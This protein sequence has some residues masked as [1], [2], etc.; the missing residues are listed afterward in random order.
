MVAHHRV[1][2]DIDRE[3]V[4]QLED[5]RPDPVPPVREVPT[6]L[7]IETAQELPPHAA[8]DDVVVRRGIERDEAAA[9]FGH[10]GLP[11]RVPGHSRSGGIGLASDELLELV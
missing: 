7:A 4:G 11:E 5:P 10:R 9:R 3:D 8:A 1:G 6:G 2:A